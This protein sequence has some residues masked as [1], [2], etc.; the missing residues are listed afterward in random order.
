M[1]QK[2]LSVLLLVLCAGSAHGMRLLHDVDNEYGRD[3]AF[4]SSAAAETET[5]QRDASLDDYEDEISR[6]EFEPERGTSYAAT[7]ATTAAAPAPGPATAGSD[8]TTTARP[9][10]GSMKW[11]LPPSTMPSFPMF[12]NP[13]GMP[14][15][16]LPAMPVPMPMPAGIPGMPAMPMPVPGGGIPGAGLPGVP[17]PGGMPAPFNFKPTGWGAGAGG[18]A[19]TTLSPPG[20]E[21]PAPPAASSSAGDNAN[22]N[23]NPSPTETI[24]N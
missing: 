6:V 18:V 22:A 14:G 8:A 4:G 15:M 10:T 13:G 1:E 2:K 9:G 20:Q 17:F 19:G 16:P 23:D 12:P 3:F 7:V 24:I 5:V 21:Q 11:W